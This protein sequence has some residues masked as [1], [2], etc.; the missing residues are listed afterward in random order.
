MPNVGPSTTATERGLGH[1]F[2]KDLPW[3]RKVYGKAGFERGML[4]AEALEQLGANFEVA[5]VPLFYPPGVMPEIVQAY[6]DPK[7]ADEQW[8]DELEDFDVTSTGI[9]GVAMIP[10]T[11]GIVRLSFDDS[12]VH[13]PLGV[14]GARYTPLQNI[15]A[16]RPFDEFVEAGELYWVNGG[17][18][19]AG[20]VV[21]LLG[22]LKG[23]IRPN[24]IRKELV[25]KF[26]VVVNAHDGSSSYRV[27]A[28]PVHVFCSNCIRWATKEAL[29][30]ANMRHTA[31]IHERAEQIHKLFVSAQKGFDTY[32]Q[33]LNRLA[34]MRVKQKQLMAFLDKYIPGKDKV[35]EETQEKVKVWT[36][37]A[38]KR[39]ERLQELFEATTAERG[40]GTGVALLNAATYETNHLQSIHSTTARETS[41]WTGTG[42]RDN[43]NA[44]R[45]LRGMV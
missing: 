21:W 34:R 19:G 26:L 24:G 36:A 2:S 1:H 16:F 12:P 11:F 14:S 17:M 28:T 33:F 18:I 15:D 5:K 7:Q 10:N 43:A 45:I 42:S 9:N 35:D 13:T 20:E 31:S 38:Q 39:R 30:Q 8:P 41:I 29:A 27:M 3:D 44:V 37:K 4:A 32:Q 22:K 25:D 6:N 40:A 23:R